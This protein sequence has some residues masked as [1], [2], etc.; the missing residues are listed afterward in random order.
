MCP[1]WVAGGKP[2][3]M[4]GAIFLAS[5]NQSSAGTTERMRKHR[6]PFK[7]ASSLP[8]SLGRSHGRFAPSNTHVSR[9]FFSDLVTTNKELD[10]RNEKCAS[11]P[12][13]GSSRKHSQK[14]N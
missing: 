14:L 11:G 6:V 13:R 1:A 10:I 9:G 8:R 7:G 2:V 12:T 5:A 4:Q 3:S